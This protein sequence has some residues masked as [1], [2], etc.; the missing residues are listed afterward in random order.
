MSSVKDNFNASSTIK[1]SNQHS[2]NSVAWKTP[3]KNVNAK[4]LKSPVTQNR[5]KSAVT[6]TLPKRLTK[7]G[8]TPNYLKKRKLDCSTPGS[9]QT[10]RAS[11]RP[12]SCSF[13]NHQ[14]NYQLGETSSFIKKIEQQPKI[15]ESQ[16]KNDTNKLNT[17]KGI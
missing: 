5:P 12:S 17:Q 14:Q 4:R 3:S 11:S 6:D 9:K 10:S 1:K 16:I 15:K 7:M 13:G 2:A 8:S